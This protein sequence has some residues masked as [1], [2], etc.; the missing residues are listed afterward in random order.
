MKLCISTLLFVFFMCACSNNPKT[1]ENPTTETPAVI[2]TP[3]FA[4]IPLE[5]GGELFNECD[6]VYYIFYELPFS[7]SYDRQATIQ[8]AV[9]WI[10]K[11]SD[12]PTSGCKSLGRM[13]FQ[14]QGAVIIEAEIYVSEDCS[15]YKWIKDG[16]VLY[17]SQMSPAGKNHYMGIINKYS[18]Q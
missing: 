18:K 5:I 6:F 14:K 2:A 1:E 10:G 13:I 16:Q 15:H 12:I 17:A 9:S 11:S 7:M 4:P 3:E 8:M